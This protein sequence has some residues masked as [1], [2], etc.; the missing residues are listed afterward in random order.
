MKKK[1]GQM[2]KCIIELELEV[3]FKDQSFPLQVY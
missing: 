2:T 1:L 3:E